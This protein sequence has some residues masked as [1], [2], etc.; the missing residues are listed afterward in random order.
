MKVEALDVQLGSSVRMRADATVH[1]KASANPEL[2]T[3]ELTGVRIDAPRVGFRGK[4][5]DV[6]ST[7]IK[8]QLPRVRVTRG[9]SPCTAFSCELHAGNAGALAVAVDAAPL[10]ALVGEFLKGENLYVRAHGAARP[11]KVQVDFD[12]AA[13]GDVEGRGIIVNGSGQPS[14]AFVA[15]AGGIT[16]GV[17]LESGQVSFK[18]L[19]S[20]DWLDGRAAVLRGPACR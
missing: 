9:A 5:D 14:G 11:D 7:W 19:A 13:A 12:H 16:S 10:R 4:G 17:S 1:A 3:V 20:F 18:P 6:R 2:E 8:A 15:Q